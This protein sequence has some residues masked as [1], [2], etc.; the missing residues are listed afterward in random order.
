MDIAQ[1]LQKPLT[2][3]EVRKLRA[4]TS[5]DKY[6]V[7]VLVSPSRT[8]RLY[9][10]TS[11]LLKNLYHFTSI[12]I[13]KIIGARNVG[14]RDPRV[15]ELAPR[16]SKRDHINVRKGGGLDWYRILDKHPEYHTTRR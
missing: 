4:R 6:Y 13:S 10:I 12:H 15:A 5:D 2:R 14:K 3:E 7:R 1:L 11:S 16:T 9:E 8:L